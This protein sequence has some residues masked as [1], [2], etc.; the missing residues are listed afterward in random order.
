MMMASHSRRGFSGRGRAGSLASGTALVALILAGVVAALPGEGRAQDTDAPVLLDEINLRV[1]GSTEGTGT[2][3]T[4]GSSG[5]ASGLDLTIRETPQSVTVVT[6]QRIRDQGDETLNQVIDLV[7]GLSA[8]QGNGE[9]R[10]SYYAR[11]SEIENLQYDGVPS[12]VHFYARDVN[13]QD[14][15]AIFDRVEVVRGA[16]GLLEGTGN[17]SASVN[18]VRKAPTA[19]AQSYIETKLTSFGNVRLTYDTSGPLTDDGR[20][21]GRFVASGAGGDGYR[22]NLEDNRGILYSAI[23]ADLTDA[24]T[25]SAGLSHAREKIDGYSWGGLWTR[26]DGSFFDFDGKTSPSLDWEFSDRKQTVG[27]LGVT[28]DF[29]GGWALDA[30]L[31]ISEGDS[32]MMYS[33]NRYEENGDLLRDGG[34]DFYINQSRSMDVRLTGPVTLFGREHDLVFG[35]N[36]SRDRTRYDSHKAY[37]VVIEDPSIA[38]PGSYPDPVF[39]PGGDYWDVVNK[40]YG[41]YASARWN[42]ADNAKVITGARVAWYDYLDSASWADSSTYGADAEFVPYLGLVYDLNDSV[43]VYGSYTGIFKPLSARGVDGQL[44][45]VEGSNLELGAKAEFLDGNLIAAAAVFQADQDGLSETDPNNQDCA[46]PG[47]TC[48]IS[49]GLIRARGAEVELTG[50]VNDRWNLWASYSYTTSEYRE[51]ERTGERYATNTS[52]RQM[53]KLGTTYDMAGA[54]EGLTVGGSLRYQSKVFADKP[55]GG[56]S[57]GGVPYYMQQGGYTLVDLMARYQISEATSV[58][59]NIDNLFDKTYYS[60]ISEPGY[61]NFIGPERSVSLSLRHNF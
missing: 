23:E 57:S 46:G 18:L 34:N 50:A 8:A 48:S 61:G 55:E 6:E 45:P 49:A 7:P 53:L 59:M 37:S 10:W 5:T 44:P 56:W 51:G 38:D 54:L 26:P 35:V 2:Y 28:H 15:M 32:E 14:D 17:P 39:S 13:P 11:G 1:D 16:T 27:Y 24:T 40:N 43:T 36:G 12:Y 52:P 60:A 33:Y 19:E 3:T 58:Q 4:A 22:D 31:R 21:R 25:I 20:V 9:M 42:V 29:G 30:R 41:I 47:P